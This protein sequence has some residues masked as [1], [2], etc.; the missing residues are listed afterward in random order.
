M[1]NLGVSPHIRTDKIIEMIRGDHAFHSYVKDIV[2]S[3]E[4]KVNSLSFPHPRNPNIV[5]KADELV[6]D[7]GKSVARLTSLVRRQHSLES[8]EEPIETVLSTVYTNTYTL[9][10]NFDDI[11]DPET[12]TILTELM[13]NPPENMT[14]SRQTTRENSELVRTTSFS[15]QFIA[16]DDPDLSTLLDN[17]TEMI[18]GNSFVLSGNDLTRSISRNVSLS[19]INPESTNTNGLGFQFSREISWDKNISNDLWKRKAEESNENAERKVMKPDWS[20]LL[21]GNGKIGSIN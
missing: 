20:L 10:D 21:P 7:S 18:R 14:V 13:D 11:L 4:K 19:N 9:D 3:A 8:S 1:L 12:L 2:P 15:T 6:S 5:V 17:F 16:P